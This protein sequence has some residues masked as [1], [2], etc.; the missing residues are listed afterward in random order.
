M[1]KA[2]VRTKALD[3]VTVSQLEH[4]LNRG[5]NKGDRNMVALC[6]TLKDITWKTAPAKHLQAYDACQHVILELLAICTNGLVPDSKLHC[7]TRPTFFLF[8]S[9]VPKLTFI[10]IYKILSQH[11]AILAVHREKPFRLA[12]GCVF[13]QVSS[14]L[15]LKLRQL[16]GKVRTLACNPMAMETL[17]P[18]FHC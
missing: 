12:D 2:K 7:V 15:G 17:D 8:F 13:E 4:A 18:W 5:F 11:Q 1:E 16:I 14:F 6:K 3:T 9:Y 10:N